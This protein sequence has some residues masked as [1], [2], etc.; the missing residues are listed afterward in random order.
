[1][2][3]LTIAELGKSAVAL[4]QKHDALARENE[5]LRRQVESTA[6]RLNEEIEYTQVLQGDRDRL[7]AALELCTRRL[8]SP[9]AERQLA[10]AGWRGANT[11]G[12][13]PINEKARDEHHTLRH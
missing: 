10:R 1:M 4:Q 13:T 7:T 5:M 8:A 11:V 9:Y 12:A 6:Q 2:K 3:R